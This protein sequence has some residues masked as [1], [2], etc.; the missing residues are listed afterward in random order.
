MQTN[1]VQTF[2]GQWESAAEAAPDQPFLRFEDSAERTTEWSYHDWDVLTARVAGRLLGLGVKRGDRVH[3]ALANSPAFL[4]VWLATARLGAV[5]VPSDPRSTSRELALHIRKARPV[6]G[7][8]G[9]REAAAY[10]RS[11][12][13][14]HV[15]RVDPEDPGLDDLADSHP[16]QDRFACGPDQPAA[17][18]FTSGTTSEPKG[19]V[20]TQGNYAF[21]GEVMARAAGVSAGDRLLV[22]LPLFHGNAQY[23]SVTAAI[24]ACATVCLMSRFSAS[25]FFAQ[26]ARSEA[27]H[28]SLFAAPIRMILARGAKPIAGL[29]LRHCWYAQNLT[30]EQID[31]FGELA[32]CRPRQLYG[33]TETVAAVLTQRDTDDA[34]GVMG[35]PTPGCDVDL[36]APGSD[37]PVAEGVV[38]E[39]TV[40]GAR[41]R[42]LFQGYFESG[43]VTD[44]SFRS[45]RFR[46]G[47]FATRDDRGRYRFIG[48]RSDILKVAGENVS[49]LEVEAVLEEHPAVVEAA[50]V[51]VAD[52]I[53]DEVPVAFVVRA[54]GRDDVDEAALL[55][56]AASRLADSKRPRS[57]AFVDAL[58]RTSVGKVRKYELRDALGAG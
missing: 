27:T 25:R 7:I 12:R 41:G 58:P 6:V 43:A 32:G 55:A 21:T 40:G 10:P 13:A 30:A 31:E 34:V 48:R 23:Y 11:D 18:L 56:Y 39:I 15:L 54:S 37:D 19:A 5:L 47:D 38:G 51:G 33:M 22:V 1:P 26:A 52:P 8:C 36:R 4:A 28:A 3:V 24:S 50:V 42:Q 44:A 53:R 46:T 35:E 57:I 49:A 16:A 2:T 29:Q 45:G 9:T 17:I 14:M 20:I